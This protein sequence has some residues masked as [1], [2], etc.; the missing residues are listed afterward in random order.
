MRA[1]TVDEKRGGP[2]FETVWRRVIC[3]SGREKM[4]ETNTEIK[5]L[6]I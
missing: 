4:E 6:S 1:I 2:G 3:E 5:V